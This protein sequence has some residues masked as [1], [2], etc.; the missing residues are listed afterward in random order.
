MDAAELIGIYLAAGSSRRMGCNKLN[1]PLGDSY[2]GSMALT[3][4]LQS[5]LQKIMIVTKRDSPLHWLASFS[6][7]KIDKLLE[8]ENAYKGQS[9]SL[10]AGI[11]EAQKQNAAGVIVILGDQ[12]LVPSK[13]INQLIDEFHISPFAPFIACLHQ[14]IPKPPVLL[15]KCLFPAVLKLNGDQGARKLLSG[16]GKLITAED[17]YFFDVDTPEDY[18]LI[19]NNWEILRGRKG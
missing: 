4:A 2:L 16:S 10:K 17:D 6:N 8:C 5:K 11:K 3:E 19:V 1:L 7:Q 15:A 13:L 12:P 9:V 18:R 14:G